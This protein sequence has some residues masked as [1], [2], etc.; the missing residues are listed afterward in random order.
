MLDGRMDMAQDGDM[1]PPLFDYYDPSTEAETLALLAAHG[2]DA[3]I[4]AG[5]QSLMPLLNMRLV[6]PATLIDVNRVESL[7]YIRDT[8]TA[9][10][11]G[12]LTRQRQVERSALVARHCPLLCDALQHVGYTPIRQRGTIG[13]SLAHADPAAEL[14]A[15]MTALEAQ[16][17]LRS[18]RGSR[19]LTPAE[20]FVTYLTTALEPDE[21]LCDVQAPLPPPR[22]GWS[23]ME[24]ARV[25]GA[26]AIVGAAVLL[27]LDTTGRCQHARLAFTGVGPVPQR[28]YQTEAVL[29]DQ[30]LDAQLLQSAAQLADHD[31]GPDSDMHAS[32]AYRRNLARVLAQRALHLAWQRA[33]EEPTV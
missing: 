22:T 19:I 29:Q 33:Q 15:V 23:F 21:L 5:G 3:K 1:K 25:A 11:I 12:A 8:P 32:A 17:V 31:L 14:P 24:V 18:Q 30:L 16:F 10:H 20:F 28:A 13:G 2:S 27:T 9:L 26:F 7:S 6:E 4:L